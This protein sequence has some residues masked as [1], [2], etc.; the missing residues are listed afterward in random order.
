MKHE[1]VEYIP[2]DLQEGV[3]YVSLEYCT[4]VHK[5][6]CGCGSEVVT[7]LSPTDWKLSFNGETISLYPS[8]GNW[9]FKCKSHYWIKN[10]SIKWAKQWSK[11]EINSGRTKDA[12]VKEK[13]FT[14]AIPS[15]SSDSNQVKE[16]IE[17]KIPKQKPN[18]WER[19]K[20]WWS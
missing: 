6:C 19:L 8:I 11:E 15:F 18:F 20:Q 3:V 17:N 5:C 9:N 2:E 10:N 16:L 7:P 12:S 14:K 1:F 13:Y 4:A